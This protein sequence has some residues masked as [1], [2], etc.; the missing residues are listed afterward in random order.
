MI[1]LLFVFYGGYIGIVLI[2]L[3]VIKALRPA[4]SGAGSVPGAIVASLVSFLIFLGAFTLVESNE[5]Y[6]YY[7]PQWRSNL[8]YFG[9]AGLFFAILILGPIVGRRVHRRLRNLSR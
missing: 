4:Y 9:T 2:A 8:L 3:L 7:G 6:W 1:L 5:S